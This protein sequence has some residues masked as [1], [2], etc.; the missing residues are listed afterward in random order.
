MPVDGPLKKQSSVKTRRY[1]WNQHHAG[2]TGSICQPVTEFT[3]NWKR[4]R[5]P[6][7]CPSPPYL[8]QNDPPRRADHFDCTCVR[9]N[10]F[11][12]FFLLLLLAPQY[13][14]VLVRRVHTASAPWRPFAV[15]H[16]CTI[17]RCPHPNSPWKPRKA[18]LRAQDLSSE[19]LFQWSPGMPG[20]FWVVLV[21]CWWSSW[22]GQSSPGGPPDVPGVCTARTAARAP[23]FSCNDSPV[24]G[25]PSP[26]APS[27]RNPP[28]PRV[29]V[30]RV[31]A[32][33][34]GPGQS[35]GLPFACCV[36]SLRS[37]GR[38][39]R[40]SCWCRCVLTALWCCLQV[41]GAQ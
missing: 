11:K 8:K 1:I 32:P 16:R 40:C 25:A 19:G 39:G 38:C 23:S 9:G 22:R 36:G 7:P 31:V 18:Q 12:H 15:E 35:P 41:S 30:R 37:V 34:R 26:T 2:L 17:R 10:A 4:R 24:A 14:R 13:V 20:G 28:P 29:T 5:P 33:L 27:P 3:Y 21:L 6:P